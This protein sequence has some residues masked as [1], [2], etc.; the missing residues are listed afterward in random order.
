[1][2]TGIVDLEPAPPVVPRY[3]ERHTAFARELERIAENVDQDLA[4]FAFVPEHVSRQGRIGLDAQRDSR[5]SGPRAEHL[6]DAA[7]CLG[8]VE[9]LLVERDLAGFDLRDRQDLVDERKQVL[10]ATA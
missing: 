4:K 2:R 10:A 9:G 6:L 1:P 3:S 8:D 7:Q 5:R